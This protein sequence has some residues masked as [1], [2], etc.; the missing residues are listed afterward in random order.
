MIFAPPNLVITIGRLLVHISR[1]PRIYE[2]CLNSFCSYYSRISKIN[3]YI[4][5]FVSGEYSL[6]GLWL[7]VESKWGV[8]FSYTRF[9]VIQSGHWRRRIWG[10]IISKI[11]HFSHSHAKQ[12][13][14]VA[15][16]LE[17]CACVSPLPLYTYCDNTRT[18]LYIYYVECKTSF[19]K[20]PGEAHTQT[21]NL[22]NSAVSDFFL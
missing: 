4:L 3:L 8:K 6:G 16:P 20:L 1:I 14:R 21:D 15:L 9:S 18:H 13:G 10:N 17:Q 2:N 12:R 11:I 19:H 7:N 5:R 22:G